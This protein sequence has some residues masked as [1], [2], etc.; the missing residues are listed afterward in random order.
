MNRGI[1]GLFVL[2]V[3]EKG[4]EKREVHSYQLSVIRLS[5][6]VK[7]QKVKRKE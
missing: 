7:M 1:V 3:K 4:S 6:R 5:G 2:S